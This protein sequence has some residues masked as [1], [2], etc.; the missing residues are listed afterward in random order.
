MG[1]SGAEAAVIPLGADAGALCGF[2]LARG[3]PLHANDEGDSA[4]EIAGPTRLLLTMTNGD[5]GAG[6]ER[7]LRNRYRADLV[8]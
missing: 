4:F 6:P 3:E 2:N 8:P 1:K 5:V 7:E